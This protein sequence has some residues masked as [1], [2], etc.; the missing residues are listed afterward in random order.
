MAMRGYKHNGNSTIAVHGKEVSR[1]EV[2]ERIKEIMVFEFNDAFIARKLGIN[3]TTA[4]Q[5]V[6]EIDQETTEFIAQNI[7]SIKGKL[8]RIAELV[9]EST[10]AKTRIELKDNEGNL[11]LEDGQPILSHDPRLLSDNDKKVI[12]KASNTIAELHDGVRAIGKNISLNISAKTLVNPAE[13]QELF[14]A[15]PEVREHLLAINARRRALMLTQGNGHGDPGR[16]GLGHSHE[17]DGVSLDTS[18][19]PGGDQSEADEGRLGPV[20]EVDHRRSAEAWKERDSFEEVP[21]LLSREF[22]ESAGHHD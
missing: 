2:R 10:I 15:D 16:S 9:I 3:R 7:P 5:L 4:W 13:Q 18:S 14:E 21:V 11:I 6:T 20:Q 22:S 19:S 1:A 8:T 12:M 17:S